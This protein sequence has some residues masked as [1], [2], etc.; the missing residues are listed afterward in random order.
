MATAARILPKELMNLTALVRSTLRKTDYWP[1]REAFLAYCKRFKGYERLGDEAFEAMANSGVTDVQG[2][3]VTL[4]FPKS[5][6]AHNYTGPPNVMPN[7]ARLTLPCVAIRGKPSVFFSEE[8]W[9]QWRAASP[10]TLFLEDQSGG[11]LL[12]L[13]RPD[14]CCELISRGLATVL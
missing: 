6:E 1:T 8:L 4:T 10:R 3:G 9:E 7:L 5:W 11:H 2:G 14:N 13:E 12:P